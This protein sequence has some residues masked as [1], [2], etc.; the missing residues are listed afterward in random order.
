MTKALMSRLRRLLVSAP[1]V[2]SGLL[3]CTR[4]APAP[5]APATK[6]PL[7]GE[8]PRS[9]SPAPAVRI[10]VLAALF[11]TSP[12]DDTARAA[13]AGGV[14]GYRQ[15]V[16]RQLEGDAVYGSLAAALAPSLKTTTYRLV[17]FVPLEEGTSRTKGKFYYRYAPCAES[18]LERVRPW[19]SPTE[20]AWVCHDDHRPQVM[21]G[22]RGQSC[23]T[24]LVAMQPSDGC[25]C[26]P[27]LM[28]CGTKTLQKRL[29]EAVREE[30]KLTVK[31][32]ITSHHP[33]GDLITSNATVRSGLADLW[34]ARVSYFLGQPFVPPDVTK[35]PSLRPRPEPFRGGILSTPA[36]LYFD[37]PRSVV[38][39]IWNNFLCVPLRSHGVDAKVLLDTVSNKDIRAKSQHHLAE[40]VGCQNCHS[41][42]EYGMQALEGWQSGYYGMHYVPKPAGETTR[43]YVKNH[44]DLRAEG[45]ANLEWLGKMIVAQPEFA[46]CMTSKVIGFVYEGETPPTMVERE[47]VRRFSD[48]Q[49]MGALI[50]SAVVARAF[51]REALNGDVARS[52]HAGGGDR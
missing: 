19:W 4:E 35:P 9:T 22:A 24:S 48:G 49:D 29:R 6:P 11:E 46:E 31:Q 38:D 34:H 23:D 14:E 1:F 7:A 27:S 45:P 37:G 33:F 51:G 26:G 21:V 28:F 20:E 42:L 18:A 47:L 12:D 30:L 25:G 44:L 39:T 32:V 50:E 3:A 16:R 5:H 40:T 15:W 10:G 8:S 36:Y 52:P 43:F 2:C 13:E 41:K 17:N